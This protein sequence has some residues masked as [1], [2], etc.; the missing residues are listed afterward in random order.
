M[1]PQFRY[2]LFPRHIPTCSAG[3]SPAPI[4]LSDE[5]SAA[6]G[7][8][9]LSYATILSQCVSALSEI[10]AASPPPSN[11]SLRLTID[12]PPESSETSAGTLVSRYENNLNFSEKLLAGLGVP[13]DTCEPVGGTVEICDNINPQGGGEYLTDDECMVGFRAQS[14]P[15]LDGRPL[16][17]MINAGVDAG[18]LRDV[19]KYDTDQSAVV[20]LVNCGLD[21]LSWFA[22][23]SFA[24]YIDSY[25]SAY[26]L[27][28]VAGN[29]WL[30]K[31]GNEPWSIY[32]EGAA[33]P[34]L[35]SQVEKK[36]KLFDVE[37][38]IRVAMTRSV[39]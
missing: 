33:G 1:S 7:V 28:N 8:R 38:Q 16:L 32:V 2:S 18:T 11:Q 25:A 27:K 22:K 3:F 24:G 6:R 19:S 37:R 4:P 39:S 17:I 9:R 13:C 26:Y 5:P 23:R 31:C 21:R 36:P 15:A 34:R 30:F 29:G 14:S 10:A 20:V 12:F 35:V